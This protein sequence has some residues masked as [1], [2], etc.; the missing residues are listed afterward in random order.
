MVD[1]NN[2]PLEGYFEDSRNADG[3]HFTESGWPTE[4]YM[5][6]QDL[7]R[8]VASYGTVAPQMGKYDIKTDSDYIFPPGTL[9][10]E[11][12]TSVGADGRVTSGCL[13]SPSDDTINSANSSWAIS[14]VPQLDVSGNPNLL[15][16]ISSISN[17]QKTTE[18]RIDDSTVNSMLFSVFQNWFVIS[19]NLHIW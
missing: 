3:D 12:A 1:W 10:K 4:A 16:P 17:S 18:T 19:C 11:V 13:F 2:R 6:F 9:L 15:S 14:S 8:L 7:Y 5:E